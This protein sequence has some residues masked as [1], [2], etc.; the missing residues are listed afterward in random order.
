MRKVTHK[1]AD[2]E[3]EFG[4]PEGRLGEFF[5]LDELTDSQATLAEL[6]FGQDVDEPLIVE[7]I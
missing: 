4:L 7:A 3:R 5:F 2:V 1:I 6:G